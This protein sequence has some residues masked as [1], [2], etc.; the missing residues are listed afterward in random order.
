MELHGGSPNPW[1]L[2]AAEFGRHPSAV[3]DKWRALTQPA[4]SLASWTPAE[5]AALLLK[6]RV[7]EGEELLAFSQYAQPIRP[8]RL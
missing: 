8:A 1:T 4:K 6:L 2:I 7:G 3:K 5:D